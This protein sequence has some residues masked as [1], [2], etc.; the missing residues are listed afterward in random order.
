MFLSFLDNFILLTVF[1]ICSLDN[2]NLDSD[3]MIDT[4]NITTTMP[5]HKNNKYASFNNMER[6][7]NG[8][9]KEIGLK[10]T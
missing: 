3:L 5:A 9:K 4:N 8:K 7:L 2:F 6:I 10:I 1:I